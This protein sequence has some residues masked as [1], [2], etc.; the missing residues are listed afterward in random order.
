MKISRRMFAAFIC[1]A[2]AVFSLASC[3]TAGSGGNDAPSASGAE[4]KSEPA[5]AADK[6]SAKKVGII[7]L[8]EHPALDAARE[9]FIKGLADAGYIEGQNLRLNVQNA[10]G[11]PSNCQTIAAQ[12]ANDDLD[13]VLCIATPAAQAAANLINDV[14]VL[15][16]AVTDPEQSGLV[17]SNDNPGGNLSGTSDMGPVEE[18]IEL[19]KKLVPEAKKLT[20]LYTSSETNSEI[21]AKIAEAKAKEIGF[22]TNI[23]TVSSSNEIQQVVEEAVSS[24]DVLYIPTDNLLASGMGVITQVAVRSKTPV[25]GGEENQLKS[26]ALATVG[27]NY[28]KLGA[29]TAAMADRVFKGEDISKMP[30]ERAK[31]VS[32]AINFDTAKAIGLEIPEEIAGK[33]ESIT[34][35]SQ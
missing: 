9:G 24:A 32:L 8:V 33:A 20:I 6:K 12:F 14:P 25:I 16:T 1:L 31:D 13:L 34:G 7:Q 15:V 29:Q 28:F 27:I 2:I 30:I 18:Q 19:A 35:E 11:D 22:D 23:M 10:Q 26:G 21:Q 4:G 5:V 17:S 3:K